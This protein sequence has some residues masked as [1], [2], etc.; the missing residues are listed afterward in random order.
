MSKP[1]KNT[2]HSNGLS[3]KTPYEI[4][5]FLCTDLG[6]ITRGRGLPLANLKSKLKVGVG[7]VPISQTI[8]PFDQTPACDLWGSHDDR[9]LIPDPDTET[10]VDFGL[11]NSPLHFFLSDIR[12]LDGSPWDVCART[13]LK[14]AIDDLKK[15]CGLSINA[16][17]EHEF[18]FLDVLEPPG[19]GFS[20]TNARHCEPFGELLMLGLQQAS[21]S[22][23]NF[24]PEF[25][26][27]QYEV[28]VDPTHAVGAADRS[29]IVQLLVRDL[30]RQLGRQASFSPK[31]TPDRIGN[32]VHIHF[33]LLDE[34]GQ[35]VCY[36]SSREGRLSETA[37]QFAA[38]VV[39][40]LPALV[41][42]TAPSSVSYLRLQPNTWSGAYACLGDR[43]REAALRICPTVN[44]PGMDVAKQHHFEYRVADAT[45]NPYLAL[46]VIVRAGLVGIR[47]K[48]H[49]PQ[50][51]NH[52]PGLL[53]D[54]ERERLGVL[55]LPGSVDTA[56]S[57]ML[58]DDTVKN[59]FS[60][61][62]LNSYLAMRRAEVATFGDR[63]PEEICNLFSSRF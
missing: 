44:M 20:I 54:D 33:G 56:L 23:D 4:V 30:A 50:L 35:P 55:R 8:T 57:A 37:G 26:L 17:F 63:T 42:F 47:E 60:D 49:Q 32:G 9:R 27:G 29:I 40:H 36:D 14:S 62:L 53:S 34:N 31:I 48:Q 39:R 24:L 22:P 52:D 61:D 43:N 12:H 1:I 38:G 41:A 11:G 25:G 10:R 19:P 51:V 6:G 5:S 59:W 21:Q 58:A 46:A 15:E 18:T 7:W 28:T 16:A 45:A 3:P 13:F 2:N